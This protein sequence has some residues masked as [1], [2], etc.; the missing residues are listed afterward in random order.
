MQI[1]RISQKILNT[2]YFFDLFNFSAKCEILTGIFIIRIVTIIGFDKFRSCVLMSSDEFFSFMQWENISTA[3]WQVIHASSRVSSGDSVTCTR[4]GRLTFNLPPCYRGALY[5]CCFAHTR[6]PRAHCAGF[7]RRR[8][9][10]RM[11]INHRQSLLAY[12][13]TNIAP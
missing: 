8:S 5:P 9:T 2:K 3:P 12:S 4:I 1:N 11:K 7:H 10:L 6:H 13:R